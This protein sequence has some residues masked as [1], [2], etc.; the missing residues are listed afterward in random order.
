M[1]RRDHGR[2][3]RPKALAGK[4]DVHGQGPGQGQESSDEED[5]FGW[6]L[7]DRA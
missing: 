2:K 7:K 1:I 4:T 3:L 6:D 5:F